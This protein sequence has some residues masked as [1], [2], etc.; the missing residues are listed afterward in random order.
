MQ[1][2]RISQAA[3]RNVNRR[4][5]WSLQIGTHRHAGREPLPGGIS[6]ALNGCGIAK[7]LV[8]PDR[9]FNKAAHCVAGDFLV[10]VQLD[11]GHFAA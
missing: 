7:G 3:H 6:M 10:L 1:A 8:Q 5:T 2:L 4:D 11:R 9:P